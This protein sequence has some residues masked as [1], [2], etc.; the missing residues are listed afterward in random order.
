MMMLITIRNALARS[1]I[2]LPWEDHDNSQCVATN[3][4]M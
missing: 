2:I 1:L 4:H 3:A